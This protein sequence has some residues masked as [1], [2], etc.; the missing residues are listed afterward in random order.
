MG[1]NMTVVIDWASELAPGEIAMWPIV[2]TTY[3]LAMG[4]RP[5]ELAD[6][7]STARCVVYEQRDSGAR[8]PIARRWIG[9]A[10]AKLG[11]R[12]QGLGRPAVATSVAA[13]MPLSD[14]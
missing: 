9:S 5:G 14:A 3:G 12:L 10:L 11:R 7:V 2:Y 1:M 4:H 8:V 13:A 6:H